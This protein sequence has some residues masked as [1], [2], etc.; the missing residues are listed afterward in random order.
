MQ[1]RLYSALQNV[2]HLFIV[3]C[4]TKHE[5]HRRCNL[6]PQ[7]TSTL[8]TKEP[9]EYNPKIFPNIQGKKTQH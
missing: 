4:D 6:F 9:C 1:H 2:P 7:G 5:N 3:S 8:K